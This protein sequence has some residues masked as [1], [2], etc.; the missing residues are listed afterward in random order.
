MLEESPFF[1]RINYSLI[2]TLQQA[3]QIT[4]NLNQV[5]PLLNLGNGVGGEIPTLPH[6]DGGHAGLS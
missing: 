1:P 6:L 3:A 5:E 4:H 2:S